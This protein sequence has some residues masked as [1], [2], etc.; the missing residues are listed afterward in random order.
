MNMNN[1]SKGAGFLFLL[2]IMLSG[3]KSQKKIKEAQ[4]AEATQQKEEVK[5]EEKPETPVTKPKT[6]EEKPEP[7][8]KNEDIAMKLNQMFASIAKPGDKS[9]K[10]ATKK[11]VLNM[12][13]SGDV[14]VLITIYQGDTVKDHDKP[15]TISRYVDYLSLTGNNNAAVENM[16]VNDQGLITLLELR[17]NYNNN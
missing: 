9:A 3:C 13:S 12:F 4:T 17:K 7:E 1:L 2:I 8:A 16:E 14:P 5:V 10:E 11:E 6:E 15:T